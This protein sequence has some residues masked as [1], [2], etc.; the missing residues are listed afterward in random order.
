[1]DEYALSSLCVVSLITTSEQFDQTP[2]HP[3]ESL[4]EL[5]SQA[6]HTHPHH[7]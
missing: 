6:E 7:N 4:T 3:T 1:M 5:P 2:K